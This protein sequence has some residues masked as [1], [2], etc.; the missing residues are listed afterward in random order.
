MLLRAMDMGTNVPK[1]LFGYD[2]LEYIGEGAG[3]AIYAVSDPVTRQLYALKHVV[4]R[5]DKDLRFIEQL[6]AEYEV[7]SKVRHPGLRRSIEIKYERTLLRRVT[8]AALVMELVDGRSLEFAMPK[9]LK[10]ILQAFI[11]TAAALSALHDA[12]YVHC[13][14][15]PNN[16]LIDAQGRIKVIDLGQAIKAG[17]VKERIQGTPD[18]ISPEQVRRDP[19]TFRTDVFNYG[20]TLYW[21][22]SGKK[23]PTLFTLAKGENSLLSDDLMETPRQA[24]PSIPEPLSNLVMECVRSNPLKR[25]ESMAVVKRRLEVIAHGLT[26]S[27]PMR[28]RPNDSSIAAAAT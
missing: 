5:T 12:G 25:P 9:T 14:L 27:S 7:G 22:L 17:T 24:N 19:V 20:A 6:E 8:E 11:D 1:S 23:L 10:G 21:A 2:V 26:S 18:Y 4:R 28:H 16:I 3:S 13:D 15:K